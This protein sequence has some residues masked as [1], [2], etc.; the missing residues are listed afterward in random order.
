MTPRFAQAIDPILLFGI[1]LVD[2]INKGKAESAPTAHLKLRS[3]FEQ[4]EAV[5]GANK[6][7]TLSKYAIVSWI[8]EMLV[9]APWPGREW[10]GNN[11]LEVHYFNTRLCHEQFYARASEASTLDLKDALEVF[12]DCVILGF[13]GFYAHTESAAQ[14]ARTRNLPHTLEEWMEKTSLAIR[15]GQDRPPL[16]EAVREIPGAPPLIS[17]QKVVVAWTGA[18]MLTLVSVIYFFAKFSS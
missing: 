9:E 14:I 15:L 4:A 7:W 3:L 12:F 10:W 16:S 18:I 1:D 2:Q 13:R 6:E 8:D 11:V 5:L 17:K